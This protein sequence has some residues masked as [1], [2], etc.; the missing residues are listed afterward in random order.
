MKKMK[1]VL[2][3][4]G[5][6]TIASPALVL[7]TSTNETDLND[8]SVVGEIPLSI[9]FA[10]KSKMTFT[11]PQHYQY[12]FKDGT[13]KSNYYFNQGFD[14]TLYGNTDYS[15]ATIKM[16]GE[17]DNKLEN[18]DL[19][20]ESEQEWEVTFN[21]TAPFLKI[22][23][24]DFD[25]WSSSPRFGIVLSKALEF[26]EDSVEITVYKST[27]SEEVYKTLKAPRITNNLNDLEFKMNNIVED[28]PIPNKYDSEW[29]GYL[30]SYN[31]WTSS[32]VT[33]DGARRL[34][35][36]WQPNVK[37]EDLLTDWRHGASADSQ[38]IRAYFIDHWRSEL[39]DLINK[40]G[41]NRFLYPPT[42]IV[43]GSVKS[44][45]GWPNNWQMSKKFQDNIGT[46][47][48]FGYNTGPKP[49]TV[50]FN[51]QNW[52]KI[53]FKT[54]KNQLMFDK[55]NTGGLA[56]VMAGWTTFDKNVDVYSFNWKAADVNPTRQ[57]YSI[58]IKEYRE[59]N[60]EYKLP[61]SV[62]FTLVKPK[63]ADQA[64][65]QVPDSEI[66]LDVDRKR[67]NADNWYSRTF[68][69]IDL[70]TARDFWTTKTTNDNP[71]VF[72]T[73]TLKTEISNFDED[74][75]DIE[76]SDA[77]IDPKDPN[78]LIFNAKYVI[79]DFKL[80]RLKSKKFVEN[81]AN[82][83]NLNKAQ[84]E[85]FVRLVKLTQNE[86]QLKEL[87]DIDNQNNGRIK[88]VDS[89]ME[90][91]NLLFKKSADFRRN[92]PSFNNYDQTYKDTFNAVL[93]DVFRTKEGKMVTTSEVQNE[94]DKI[95]TLWNYFDTLEKINQ[96]SN[97]SPAQKTHFIDQVNEA[98]K[99]DASTN[100]NKLSVFNDALTNAQ[101]VDSVMKK[102]QKMIEKSEAAKADTA[103]YDTYEEASK[104]TFED[105]LQKAKNE[106]DAATNIETLNKLYKNLKD[107]YN[108]LNTANPE[109]NLKDKKDEAIS[110]L[111]QLKNINEKQKN[112]LELKIEEATSQDEID[113]IIKSKE[114]NGV[115]TLEGSAKDLDD[116]MKALK[117]LIKESETLKNSNDIKYTHADKD[118]QDAFKEAIDHAKNALSSL[119]SEIAN[120]VKEFNALDVAKQALN[121]KQNL[122]NAKD[123]AKDLV[124]NLENLNEKQK[125][126]IK[127]LIDSKN[128][129]HEVNEIISKSEQEDGSVVI[130]GPAKNLDDAMKELR[131]QIGKSQLVKPTNKYN[132]A[133]QNLKDAFDQS[134]A[135]ATA[136][137]DEQNDNNNNNTIDFD[138]EIA[139]IN[140]LKDE[141]K[142]DTAA[143]NGV[144][145]AKDEII[146]EIVTDNNLTIAEKDQLIDLLDETEDNAKINEIKSFKDQLS[147]KTKELRELQEKAKQIKNSHV[148][149]NA[150]D[151]KKINLSNQIDENSAFLDD[152]TNDE[153]YY[154]NHE[155]VNDILNEIERLKQETQE[156]I[157]QLSVSAKANRDQAESNAILSLDD[158]TYLNNAQ[159][160]NFT[161]E[162]QNSPAIKG[163]S[164]SIE[165]IVKQA[166]LVNDKMRELHEYVKNTIQKGNDSDPYLD[167]N[168]IDADQ[169]LKDNFKE[170]YEKALYNL[171]KDT[172]N[173]LSTSEIDEVLV[174]LKQDYEALNGNQRRTEKIK[175]LQ[176]LID[177]EE[178]VHNSVDYQNGE[179]EKQENYDNAIQNGKD[180]VKD[181][182]KYNL[183]QIQDA[184]VQI[185]EAKKDL[186]NSKIDVKDQIN[187]LENLS[188]TEKEHF[189]ELA[190]DATTNTEAEKV[191]DDAKAHN[192][193]K[194]DL[195]N[196]VKN[197][198][199]LSDSDKEQLIEKIKNTEF[200]D[201]SQFNNVKNQVSEVD[202]L[203]EK[204]LNPETNTK[205]SDAEID[206]ILDKIKEAGINNED[207]VKVGQAI[208]DLKRLQDALE[209]YRN[210]TIS[211]PEYPVKKSYLEELINLLSHSQLKDP[212]IQAAYDKVKEQQDKIAKVGQIEINLV[213]AIMKKDKQ[214]FDQ[215]MNELKLVDPQKY[216]EFTKELDEINYFEL[217]I[218]DYNALVDEEIEKLANLTQK[219]ASNVIFSA[220]QNHYEAIKGLTIKDK[221]SIW[222]YILLAIWGVLTI[223]FVYL[224]AKNKKSK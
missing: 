167:N 112:E 216:A 206:Q 113:R 101:K 171:N 45:N 77:Q 4:F 191:L 17:R 30:T 43:D 102:L 120:A 213:D 142:K 173:N 98:M 141:L 180:I 185:K 105:A 125:E 111:D 197:Q 223:P 156:A 209:Q 1:I 97:L 86:E 73:W 50:D 49:A 110:L 26:V 58:D 211:V 122:Q 83:V 205:L 38:P 71:D 59:K 203:I 53:T 188:D 137:R 166:K 54:R 123:Q 68:G 145:S 202:K 174:K 92:N 212:K 12:N 221:L 163:E 96:L 89:K 199:H 20:Y 130:S 70:E 157:D 139:K 179:S 134:L 135:G 5:V 56:Y 117:E 108:G 78:R 162:I 184:I 176:D 100:D 153:D 7:S 107:A 80:K 175:E 15:I 190:D 13:L 36:T 47:L 131:A 85:E 75:W 116:K 16:K 168:Y 128:S 51:D 200:K 121:G 177:K 42:S 52:F 35:P 106:K 21:R 149:K 8:V 31:R 6:I 193:K 64:E 94:I 76:I 160:S 161:Y 25:M 19:W 90:E 198:E 37:Y 27:Q 186:D 158:L 44:G 210:S 95:K 224:I 215:K 82:F 60:V 201:D 57:N 40:K 119:D 164:N 214:M 172:G 10:D 129:I 18:Q 63:D 192:K 220:A 208:K 150:D 165:E 34:E 146:H 29:L 61:E 32:L 9:A 195:I 72:P 151:D 79:N 2:G 39:E 33:W 182:D 109:N 104:K 133:D 155:N 103:T 88:D 132:K 138:S 118:K 14:R 66:K 170:S 189:N 115:T 65:V 169:K 127:N 69:S 144:V 3:S 87:I 124:A 55:K 126:A 140:L 219:D 187:N 62:K 136:K 11:N 181:S 159:K 99:N 183:D 93:K 147:D 148:Y 48:G 196:F 154:N 204:L 41:G 152:T 23:G 74:I 22:E 67:R 24:Y 143:L 207:Y 114:D 84:R 222:W 46:I 28:I 178:E 217:V 81:P 91:L 218:K 194:E